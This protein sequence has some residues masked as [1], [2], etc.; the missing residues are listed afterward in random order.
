MDKPRIFLGS[1][2][3]QAALVQA[4]TR[5]LKDVAHVD[6][7]TTSFN[8]GTTTLERLVELAHEVDFAA[9]A[10]AQDDWT[11]VNTSATPP[12][13]SGQASPRDNVVFE[14]GLF[15]GVLGMRRTFILHA[16]GSKL[17]TDLLG[18]TSIRYGD[19]TAAETRV[20]CQ[21]LRKAIE[22]EGRLA[23]IEGLWWQFSLTERSQEE[24]SA[25]SLLRIGRDRNG[26]MEVTGRSWQE[27]GKLSARYWSEATKEKKEPS[28]VFYYWRGERPLDPNAPQLDGT[29]EIRL[30][31]AD[32]AA[33][34]WTTR[35]DGP[36]KVN[37]R[38][39]GVYLRAAPSDMET[40]DGQDNRQRVKLIADKLKH[41]KSIKA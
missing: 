38:T 32:R 29:G 34:Y 19:V 22:D 1:S 28:G 35:A 37:A 21:K 17:P 15:G 7:W 26:A 20:V 25:L 6:P 9:F 23:R 41:W 24:P 27:D 2:G 4:L 13:D 33:G 39:V 16:R 3:K 12:P 40:L 8:P 18:L 36:Q 31:A 10:F 11:A 14:A 30:E 5:G